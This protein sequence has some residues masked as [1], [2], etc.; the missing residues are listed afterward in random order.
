M[1]HMVEGREEGHPLL[2]NARREGD[3]ASHGRGA[4]D[5]R[6]ECRM[7]RLTLFRALDAM[8]A[9]HADEGHNKH[10]HRR[11]IIAHKK[12]MSK[13]NKQTNT[14][15]GYVMG[16]VRVGFVFC[17]FFSWFFLVFGF[18]GFFFD[19]LKYLRGSCWPQV[20]EYHSLLQLKG[21]I[22]I[23]ST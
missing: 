2:T 7:G 4:A 21:D 14:M 8:Q 5:Q 10:Y 19:F 18:F 17:L 9:G 15:Q 13:T 23:L 11:E 16:C 12:R 6:N 22:S 20:A 1:K 3:K